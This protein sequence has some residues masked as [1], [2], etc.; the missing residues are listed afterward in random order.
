MGGRG[1]RYITGSTISETLKV[2][3]K[4]A[5]GFNMSLV[6]GKCSGKRKTELSSQNAG[7]QAINYDS[8]KGAKSSKYL[9]KMKL[10]VEK[11]PK[12]KPINLL[13]F[14]TNV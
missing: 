14:S 12:G 6:Q 1:R 11:R 9:L 4:V 13:M 7:P 8:G 2:G 10:Y 3:R 5:S